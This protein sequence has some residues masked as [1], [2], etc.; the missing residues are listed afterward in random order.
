MNG[1]EVS[2]VLTWHAA[3]NAGDAERVVALSTEDVEVGGPRGAGR[4]ADVLRDWVGRSGIRLVPRRVYAG[5]QTVVVEQEATWPAAA[6]PHVL[7]SV[8]GVRAGRVAR[9][10]RFDDLSS[11]LA[12]SSLDESALV[13]DA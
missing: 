11:A 3:L 2:T 13:A 8:F 6:G 1:D 4:G 9:V 10:I 5:A 12:A 7:A